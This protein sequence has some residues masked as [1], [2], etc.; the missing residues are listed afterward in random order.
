MM[1]ATAVAA[2]AAA[3]YGSPWEHLADELGRLTLRLGMRA[4]L[5]RPRVRGPL[6]SFRGLVVSD[7]EVTALLD[8]LATP[9]SEA[10]ADGSQWLE[11]LSRMDRH[12]DE[13]LA[14]SRHQGLEVPLVRL[15]RLFRLTAFEAQCV[16]VCLAPELDRRYETLYG[17]LQD[18]VTQKRPTVG[19]VLDLFCTTDEERLAARAPFDPQAPLFRYRLCRPTDAALDHALPL[20][21]RPLALDD[22]IVDFLL[23]RKRMDRRLD[24]VAR[25][26]PPD[27][28]TP[29][30][31][32]RELTGR[33]LAAIERSC[34]QT[35]AQALFHLYGPRGAGT[36]SIAE[37]VCRELGV[38]LIVADIERILAG[39]Q[40][41]ADAIGLLVRE[42]LLWPAAL[43]L[44]HLD[45]LLDDAVRNAPHLRS[46]VTAAGLS[47]RLTFTTGRRAW[48]PQPLADDRPF[49]G[50]EV[51]LPDSATSRTV[52]EN[53][54]RLLPDVADEVDWGNLASRFRFGP[55]QIRDALVLAQNL[56]RWRPGAGQV[57]MA[58]L[59]E[60]CRTLGATRLTSL[61]GK[62]EH[63][64]KWN[65]IVLPAH[66]LALLTE[67]CNEAR[68]RQ[69]VLGRW[70]FDRKLSLG[71]GL[72]A[73]FSGPPGTGKTMAAQITAGELD[74]DLHRIDLSQVVSK[75]VGDTEK[76][77]RQVFEDAEASNAILFFDEADA[78]F[79]KRSD[80]KDAHDRY[81]NIEVGYLLQKMEEFQGIA[82]LATNLRQN[83]DDA[84]VRRL[85]FIIEF[86]FPDEEHR[87]RIWRVTFPEQAPL[88]SDVDFT[89]L[90]RD[91]RLAGGHIRN[92]G[93]TAAYYAA[94][95]GGTIQ[96]AHLLRAA[97]REYEKLGR[98]WI[99][100]A[101]ARRE[102]RR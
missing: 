56:T 31:A 18:D 71:K 53:C 16:L 66:P 60:A 3:P 26:V 36:R 75:Y 11:Y 25:M 101:S 47:S 49:F 12:V 73:M 45:A 48:L 69:V 82:I 1:H 32:D 17:Y 59:N 6:D 22:R 58:D 95:D 14:A 24:D 64:Q 72:T 10:D 38:P 37:T 20:L 8:E 100:G 33:M 98:T 94:G 19:L 44:E 67:L 27:D 90:A 9:A 83:L 78:L 52:W 63:R 74:L 57:T 29:L 39:S 79:G 77:L 30:A 96:M 51:R 50:V 81:A 70:G 2:P 91:V 28:T 86:P 76:N 40:P 43:C 62:V 80:V 102:V 89:A 68:H 21:R 42:A 97:A 54:G 87:A 55:D 65:D 61:A 23:G 93:L 84:F 34:E 99:E 85:R 92:I 5:R 46:L 13:R 7:D 35:G 15:A 88:G 4:R 41:F